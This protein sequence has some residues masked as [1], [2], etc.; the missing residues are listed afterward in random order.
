MLTRSSPSGGGAASYTDAE[1]ADAYIRP[2]ATASRN[3]QIS[4][5]VSATLRDHSQLIPLAIANTTVA[6]LTT[7]HVL[8]PRQLGLVFLPPSG[9]AVEQT[10]LVL[11]RLVERHLVL[12]LAALLCE[13]AHALV[14]PL[15]AVDLGA[16]LGE[17]DSA[18]S[19]A[20]AR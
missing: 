19:A 11:R 4:V 2:A 5:S 3:T 17:A 10:Q 6:A 14:H 7:T 20:A 15:V 16:A 9:Q 18:S 12:V 13:G 1:T 8:L